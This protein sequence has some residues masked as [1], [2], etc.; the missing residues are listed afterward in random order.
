LGDRVELLGY[1][2][3]RE[4]VRPGESIHLT[5]IWRSLREMDTSYTVFTHV[6][7]QAEQIRGQQDN[8]PVAGTYPT[9]LWVPGEVVVDRYDIAIRADTPPGMHVIEVGLYDPATL[10]R[11]PVLDPSGALG[12]RILLGQI[13]IRF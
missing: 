9:T 7:D 4:E 6:L 11:L 8:P 5:L 3:D 10:Q 1:D 12:D 13:E 2:L